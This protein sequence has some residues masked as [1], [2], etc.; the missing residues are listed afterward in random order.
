MLTMQAGY[1]L[2]GRIAE[3]SMR[4]GKLGVVDLS[5]ATPRVVSSAAQDVNYGM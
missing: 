2:A 4:I 5:R 3:T 1:C